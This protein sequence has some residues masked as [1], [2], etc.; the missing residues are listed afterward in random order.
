M[1][2]FLM[3]PDAP[4]P[5]APFSHAT[6]ADGWLFVTGQMPTDPDDDNAPLV[7]DWLSRL[8]DYDSRKMVRYL[9]VENVTFRSEQVK[10]AVAKAIKSYD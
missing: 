6:V 9:F 8:R 5:V 4:K 10:Q 7:E 1:I 2:E 3:V